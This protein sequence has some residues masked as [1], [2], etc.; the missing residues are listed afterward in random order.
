M[1]SP[2]LRCLPLIGLLGFTVLLAACRDPGSGSASP[3]PQA[4]P[5]PKR[6]TVEAFAKAR[7]NADALLVDVRTPAEFAQGHIPGA[8]NLDVNSDSFASS[9]RQWDRNRP[10]LVYCRSGRRSAR[11]CSMLHE[12]GFTQLLDLAPGLQG[13]EAA[14]QPVAR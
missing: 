10:I 7:G 2:P 14:G 5:G 6:V 4:T 3:A 1:E 8:I 13:W 11:A 9:I 12:T